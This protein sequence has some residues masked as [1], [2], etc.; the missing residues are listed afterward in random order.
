MAQNLILITSLRSIVRVKNQTLIENF[1]RLI[2]GFGFSFF[3]LFSRFSDSPVCLSLTI[4]RYENY[5][6]T[7]NYFKIILKENAS[8]F[9]VVSMT[10]NG[11][12]YHFAT[13]AVMS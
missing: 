2:K 8:F 3:L 10:I 1:A 4:Q 7:P 12:T 9:L 5:L 6:K 13:I 11:Y